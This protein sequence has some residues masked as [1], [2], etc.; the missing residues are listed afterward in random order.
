MPAWRDGPP[1]VMTEM[2]AAEPALAGRIVGRLHEDPALGHLV[3]MVSA[4]AHEGLTITLTGCG[5]SEHAALAVAALAS[6]GL[7]RS[8]RPAHG[9][10][11]VQA[12]E[13]P[14]ADPSGGPVI[15]VS[16]EGGTDATNAAL[17][18]SG[19]SDGPTA[20]ITVS[21]RSPGA[22]LAR[23]VMATGEQDQSWCHTVGYLSPL[24]AG[25]CLHAALV[26][27]ELAGEAATRQ[28]AA[29][30]DETTAEELAASLSG[31][32]RLLVVGSG[33][34]YPAAR[35]L[36][37]KVEEGARLPATAHAL[38]T[39]RHG[40]LAAA[41]ERTGLVV[42]L[43][44]GD[45]RGADVRERAAAV[46]RA[47][48]ALGMPSVV[49]GSTD[50]AASTQGATNRQLVELDGT[51]ARRVAALL[52]VVTPLQLLTERLARARGLNPDTLGREDPR[53]AAAASA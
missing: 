7:A 12:F 4:A 33:I 44:D 37:L 42:V 20:L 23:V 38:E 36:A 29:G 24:I 50:V 9:A 6:D 49:I 8:G 22:A 25:A 40:H 39:I 35:E 48:A 28:L 52:A 26:G 51:L 11:T 16:H 27:S 46:L 17:R 3:D 13:L 31:T 15:A 53:Q 43:T 14:A 5:T 10:R 21:D 45:G 32:D 41:T 1:Y 19:G 47:G 30:T 18:R 34:D 2:I